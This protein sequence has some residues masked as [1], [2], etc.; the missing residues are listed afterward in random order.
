MKILGYTI[1]RGIGKNS[2]PLEIKTKQ[3]E[4]LILSVAEHVK[5]HSTWKLKIL[6]VNKENLGVAPILTTTV[7]E[8]V[9]VCNNVEEFIRDRFGAGPF[10]VVIYRPDGHQVAT[11]DVPVGGPKAYRPAGV[12]IHVTQDGERKKT[13][14]SIED[15]VA[16]V[17]ALKVLIPEPDTSMKGVFA[18][19]PKKYVPRI[20]QLGVAHLPKGGYSRI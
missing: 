9:Q 16:L 6:Y 10:R 18:Y 15:I 8:F 7:G 12:G 19:P 5:N 13:S 3:A 17:G 11:Y 20:L 2:A 4:T 1:E 14:S